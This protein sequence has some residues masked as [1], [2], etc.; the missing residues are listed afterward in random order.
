MHAAKT[1]TA[2]LAFGRWPGVLATL[3]IDD[4]FLRNKHGPCPMCA[5]RDRYRFDDKNRGSWICS[6]CGAGDGFKLLQGV[7]GWSFS[8]A[9]KQIDRIVGT[10]PAGPI[11]AERTDDSKIRALRQVWEGSKEVSRGDPVWKYLNGRLGIEQIPAGLRFHPSLRYTDEN[12][13]EL[14]HFPAMLA[15]LQ[16]PDGAGASIHRTYLTPDGAKAP[17]PQP[18]K[19]MPG[20][21][22]ISAAVRLGK[23]GPA[24]GVAEGIET[25]LAAAARFGVPVWAATN[26]ALLESWAPPP[27]IERVLVA[28]DNDASFTGQA[29]AFNLAR[30]LTRK[31]YAVE[32][33]IPESVDTDWANNF[34]KGSK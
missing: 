19:I 21:S 34:V 2:D 9:A 11:A 32:V 13:R 26:A 31:G 1:R 7:M 15:R 17:V 24:L 14:G 10:V 16:Y 33:V 6:H 25:A 5:G 3:G 29:A 12:G 30:R 28:A 8:E 22:L 4:S 20:K 18:K 27:G 23:L